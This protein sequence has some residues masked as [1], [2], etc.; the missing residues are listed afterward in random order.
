MPIYISH[1]PNLKEIRKELNARAL[2]PF[3]N[4]LPWP[5]NGMVND[6]CGCIQTGGNYLAALGLVCYIEACGRQIFFNNEMDSK[7]N[8]PSF[9]KFLNEYMGLGFLLKYKFPFEGR[10]ITF[11]NAVRNG[12]VHRYFLKADS[13]GVCMITNDPIANKC[14]FFI[15]RP[16]HLTMAVVPLFKFFCAGLQKAKKEGVLK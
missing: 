14:G 11:R 1:H 5:Y 6:L 16:G 10:N 15:S 8:A 13:S 2:Q 3:V 7:W 12:L 9:E 4:R